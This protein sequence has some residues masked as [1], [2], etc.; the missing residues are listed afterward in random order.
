[1]VEG[2]T[3]IQENQGSCKQI[4]KVYWRSEKRKKRKTR[5]WEKMHAIYRERVCMQWKHSPGEQQNTPQTQ[6]DN[7]QKNTET[8]GVKDHR[9]QIHSH[10]STQQSSLL[11]QPFLAI[12]SFNIP[13]LKGILLI[14]KKTCLRQLDLHETVLSF[15]YCGAESKLTF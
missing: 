6:T 10:R 12:S 9:S 7:R 2:K 8:D 13:E 11:S 5:K 14:I 3:L 1:M 15:R 4:P